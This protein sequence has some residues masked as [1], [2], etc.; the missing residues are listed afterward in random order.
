MFNLAKNTLPKAPE[1]RVLMMVKDEKLTFEVVISLSSAAS[2]AAA[3]FLESA[4]D[5][6]SCGRD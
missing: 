3:F 4:F 1:P 6:S 5:S 2:S